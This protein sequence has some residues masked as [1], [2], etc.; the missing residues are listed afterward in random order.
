MAVILGPL[1]GLPML[2]MGVETGYAAIVAIPDV[3]WSDAAAAATGDWPA[4][5]EINGGRTHC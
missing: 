3:K 1:P 2:E 4:L 5:E